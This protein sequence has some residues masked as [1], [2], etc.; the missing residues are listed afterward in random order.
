MKRLPV[1]V[2]G[3]GTRPLEDLAR[4]KYSDSYSSI[5]REQAKRRVAILINPRGRDLEGF[6][7]EASRKLDEAKLMPQGYYA[8]WGGSFQNLRV[9]RTRLA[10]LTPLALALVLMMVY[11]AFRSV[12]LTLLVFTG[13]PLALVGGVAALAMRGMPFSISAG[14]G[15]IAL[16]GIAALNGVVLISSAL[17]LFR[18]KAPWPEAI[19]TAAETRLRPV[20]MTALVDIFGFLPMMYSS[21]L[22]A[23]VQQPLATVVVGGVISSTALTLLMLPSWGARIKKLGIPGEVHVPLKA[24]RRPVRAIK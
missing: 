19:R 5:S 21:G 18:D 11:A 12:K 6:V 1:G 9:A 7:N 10:L 2:G 14:V 17:A 16:A 15:F 20:L 8:E 4:L 22:G 3:G 23:E 24:D 13:I